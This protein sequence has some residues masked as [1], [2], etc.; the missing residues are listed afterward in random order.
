PPVRRDPGLRPEGPR[1]R[2]RIPRDAPVQRNPDRKLMPDMLSVPTA[3]PAPSGPPDSASAPPGRETEGPPFKEVL[4]DHQARTATAE[5]RSG[6]DDTPK[7]T[8]N[9][10]SATTG[11]DAKAQQDPCAAALP[12]GTVQALALTPAVPAARVATATTATA[13]A[14]TPAAAATT[15]IAAD[16]LAVAR[17]TEQAAAEGDDPECT[18]ATSAV[19]VV[20]AC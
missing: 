2:P 7:G 9:D 18:T 20:P 5:G 15:A 3:P 6:G 17:A 8:D 4:K 12:P 1:L 13:P 16:Q 11:Q 14:A 19:S 10:D